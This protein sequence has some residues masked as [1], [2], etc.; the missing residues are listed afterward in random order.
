M[1]GQSN[2]VKATEAYFSDI[3]SGSVGGDFAACLAVIPNIVFPTMNDKFLA[4]ISESEVER[5]VFS[6]E[7]LK[8]PGPD[9]LN[10]EFF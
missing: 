7:A 4:S 8:T 10:G 2:I 1:E 5:A 3:Y 9:G 6:L